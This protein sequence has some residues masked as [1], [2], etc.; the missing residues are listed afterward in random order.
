ML[1]RAWSGP[2][3][4]SST[5]GNVALTLT[6][7]G[8][9]ETRRAHADQ[10]KPFMFTATTPRELRRR[11]EPSRPSQAEQ[12]KVL[13]R[14]RR[15]EAQMGDADASALI[16]DPDDDSIDDVEYVVEAIIGHFHTPQDFWFLVKWVDYVEPTWEH[17]SLLE[18][19]KRVTEY[20]KYVCQSEE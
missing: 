14:I 12:D 8:A 20:F 10:V 17:E 7:V 4:V 16:D 3:V 1:R 5:W 18:A 11:K 9:T 2:W 15:H 6:R 19:G 13:K